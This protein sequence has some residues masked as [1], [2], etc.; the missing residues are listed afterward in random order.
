MHEVDAHKGDWV[1]LSLRFISQ[2]TSNFDKAW[3][4]LSTKRCQEKCILVTIGSTQNTLYMK[5][6]KEIG[7][8]QDTSCGTFSDLSIII[9][10]IFAVWIFKERKINLA[11]IYF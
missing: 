7:N 4:W 8:L 9:W 11:V 3:Y 6:H 2:I 10:H 5:G 1:Y